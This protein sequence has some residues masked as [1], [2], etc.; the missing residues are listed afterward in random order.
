MRKSDRS[1]MNIPFTLAAHKLNGEFLK[2]A[3]TRAMGQLKGHRDVGGMINAMPI[4][5]VKQLVE[6]MKEFEAKR[7]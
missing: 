1:R 4:E 3:E 5:G 7:R 6:Y 2:S